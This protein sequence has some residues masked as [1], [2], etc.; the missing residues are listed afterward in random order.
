MIQIRN[1]QR[2]EGLHIIGC[3]TRRRPVQI[4][5]DKSVQPGP[6]VYWGYHFFFVIDEMTVGNFWIHIHTDGIDYSITT[7]GRTEFRWS[8][9]GHK[10]IATPD[11]FLCT[12]KEA[13]IL[14]GW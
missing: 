1:T 7:P 10:C 2:V 11:D 4:I 14:A 3:T 9:S 5:V 8:Q 6:G 13:M 12:L